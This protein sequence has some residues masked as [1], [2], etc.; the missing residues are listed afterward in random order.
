MPVG[1]EVFAGNR[2]DTTT[3]QQIVKLMEE[4]YGHANRVW[5][6]DRGM[7]SEENIAFLEARE[8]FYLMGA[9]RSLLKRYEY[10]FHDGGGWQC[11][12]EGLSVS[13]P[14]KDLALLLSR[15]KLRLPHAPLTLKM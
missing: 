1:Y 12:R 6:T 13:K 8:S 3:M 11:I 5:V 7:S 15:M 14:E 4:K 2:A 9:P 10:E